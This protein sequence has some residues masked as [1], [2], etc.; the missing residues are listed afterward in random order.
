GA[1]FGEKNG[2]ERVNYFDPDRPWRRAGADQRVWGWV[3]PPYFEQVGEEHRA[4]RERVGI[5]DMTSFGKIEVSGPGALS[6][7]QELTDNQIDKPVGRVTYTQFL[8]SRG[9]IES[10]LTVTRLGEDRFRVISGSAFVGQDLGWILLH[11]PQDGSV[12]VREVTEELSCIGLWGPDSRRVLQAVTDS[13]VS[14]ESLPYMSAAWIDASGSEILAQRVTYVGELGWELYT[15]R[16]QAIPVWETLMEA[17]HEFGIQPAGYKALESLRLEKGYRYWSADMTPAENPYE[18]G[19][20]FCVRLRKGEFIGREALLRVKEQGPNRRL[21]TLAV[22]AEPGDLYG[23]EAVYADGRL[24][25]RVRSGGYGY[26]VEKNIALAY[27]PIELAEQGKNLQ[28]EV[29]GEQSGANV[30][31]D[32]LYDPDRSRL[33]A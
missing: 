18:A 11:A 15:P 29:F 9:G 12:E 31:P 26:T 25:G 22:E 27:L 32:V 13:D 10:D 8:N 21:S 1:V 7:L 17:G 3:R 14:N 28:V 4:V 6:L 5:F 33:K 2:W 23:G 16:G 24:V 20:G 30:V 19:L